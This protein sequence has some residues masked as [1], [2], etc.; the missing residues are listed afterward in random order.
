MTQGPDGFLRFADE[1]AVHRMLRADR[2][3]AVFDGTGVVMYTS[4][5]PRLIFPDDIR[6]LHTAQQA[7]IAV[8]RINGQPNELLDALGASGFA[9][10]QTNVVERF[11]V[12]L[13]TLPAG[14]SVQV[15]SHRG[16]VPHVYRESGLSPSPAN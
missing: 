3:D 7:R 6:S 8:V 9:P 2:P 12:D 4:V 16:F 10:D 14:T 15:N 1:D 13:F 11:E 5:D